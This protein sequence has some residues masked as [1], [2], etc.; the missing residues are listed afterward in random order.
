LKNAEN[1]CGAADQPAHPMSTL[2]PIAS[3][4]DCV[5]AA[6]SVVASGF[7]CGRPTGGTA[8]DGYLIDDIKRRL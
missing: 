6:A 3:A 2:T 4:A 1:A 7:A 8:R 5:V